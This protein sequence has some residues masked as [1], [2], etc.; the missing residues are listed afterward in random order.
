MPFQNTIMPD[1]TVSEMRGVWS[2]LDLVGN[3]KAQAAADFLKKISAEKDAAVERANAAMDAVRKSE[4]NRAE[5]E[6]Y[7]ADVKARQADME[8]RLSRME[9]D[10]RQK[11]GAHEKIVESLRQREDDLRANQTQHASAV[12]AW[13]KEVEI[14]KAAHVRRE[15]QLVEREMKLDEAQEDLEH[16]Q[17]EFNRQMAPVLA[18]AALA[19]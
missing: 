16:R 2:L 5:A 4:A 6:N 19:R 8:G 14:A 10:L 1:V 15:S 7:A 11:I 18:A 17:A 13:Q 9:A 12:V 3:P